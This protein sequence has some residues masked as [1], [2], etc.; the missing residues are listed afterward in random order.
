MKIAYRE[1]KNVIDVNTEMITGLVIENPEFMYKMLQ[2]FRKATEGLD[3]DIVVSDNET[4]IPAQKTIAYITDFV[5]FTLNQKTLISKIMSELDKKSKNELYYEK[6]ERLL[7]TI[8]MYIESIAGDLPCE[9][10]CEKLNMLAVIKAAGIEIIDDYDTLEERILAYMD[11]FREY[12]GKR[13]FV[14]VNLRSVVSYATLQLMMATAITRDYRVLLID[15]MDYKKL[16]CES[17]IIIDNDLC[18][19]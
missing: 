5:D 3:S 17:R 2:E 13:L 4:P 12:E 10:I 16:S 18:V 8:E 9:I 15:N 19:I 14:F 7:E 11:L 1:L 6:S